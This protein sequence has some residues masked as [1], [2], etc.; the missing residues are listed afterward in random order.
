VAGDCALAASVRTGT[1]GIDLPLSQIVF[2]WRALAHTASDSI[3]RAIE[4]R[5]PTNALRSSPA[6]AARPPPRWSSGR[7]PDQA[8]RVVNAAQLARQDQ[9]AGA[10][11]RTLAP[12]PTRVAPACPTRRANSP[13]TGQVMILG[14]SVLRGRVAARS[15]DLLVTE[16]AY[17]IASDEP[18]AAQTLEEMAGRLGV[19]TDPVGKVRRPQRALANGIGWLTQA[20]M[21][22]RIRVGN[23]GSRSRMRCDARTLA[24]VDHQSRN[25]RSGV[26]RR[27]Q[28]PRTARPGA[29][30][31]FSVEPRTLSKLS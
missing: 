24:D 20:T 1:I 2:V 22:R 19:A 30:G 6:S 27:L 8:G 7:R 17:Y 25:S 31:R 11:T 3:R 9:A 5:N 28:C 29:F 10:A 21:P 4:W 12:L 15:L 18:K 23:F 13:P 26:D 14:N 16:P